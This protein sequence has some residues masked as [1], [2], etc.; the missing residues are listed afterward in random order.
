MRLYHMS[1][2]AILNR[3]SIATFLLAR[4][5]KKEFLVAYRNW[6]WKM[7]LF[8]FISSKRRKSWVDPGQ[9]STSTLKRNFHGRKTLFCIWWNQENVLY[10][11]PLR[12]KEIVIADRYQQQLRWFGDELIQKRPFVANSRRKVIL[13]HDNA[14]CEKRKAETSRAD[15][16]RES[17][18][19]QRTPQTWRCRIIISS[20]RCNTHL[21]TR[22][23][24]VTEKFK[25]WWMNGS[26][27]ETPRFIF[28][29]LSCCWRDGENS[30]I[31]NERNYLD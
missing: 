6:R 20:D 26:S 3:L 8:W 30:N 18:R 23:S 10:Y 15:R 5:R 12:S 16:A 31:T 9:S 19:I 21:Q 1:E 17:F 14:C 28:V 7:N 13:L 22:T 11:E 2:N 24:T 4:Q 27:R 29:G 25:N